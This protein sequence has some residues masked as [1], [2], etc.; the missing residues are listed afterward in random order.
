MST[1]NSIRSMF[2]NAKWL[3]RAGGLR[4]DLDDQ[5]K[6]LYDISADLVKV[7]NQLA[8]LQTAAQLML[9]C[10]RS[11]GW[12][13]GHHMA[14]D[15]EDTVVSLRLC[16]EGSFEHF[17][18]ELT[19]KEV[20]AGDVVVDVGANIG[21]YTLLFARLVGPQGHVFAFEPDPH[22]FELLRRNV[23][24]N[25]YQN[26]TLVPCA[27]AD[28]AGSV[29]LFRNEGNRGDH[30]IYESSED[31]ESIEVPTVSLDDY[32][33]NATHSIDFVK[34]DIQGAEAKALRGMRQLLKRHHAVRLMT[35]FWPRGLKL[36]G[37]DGRKFLDELRTLGFDVSVINEKTRQ[38]LPANT[39]ELL[40]SLPV[41]P[42]HDLGFTNLYCRRAA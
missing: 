27:V 13:Y 12:V 22:N 39:N 40:A 7:Q 28:Q 31:R 16:T 34:M 19:L 30:R 26:V 41:E 37:D 9:R 25:N 35:E 8:D 24:Q 6:H 2:R 11:Q 4:K 5:R 36:C 1:I 18:T 42:E 20:K 21:Y 15:P 14:L 23:L 38:V 10:Q 3:F 32:F 29:R 33:R 17:E